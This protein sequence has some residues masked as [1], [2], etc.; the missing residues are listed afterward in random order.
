MNRTQMLA[1]LEGSAANLALL[2]DRWDTLTAAERRQVVA[3]LA[4][5]Q[6]AALRLGVAPFPGI[7]DA[8]GLGVPPLVL[9]AVGIAGAGSWIGWKLRALFRDSS[10]AVAYN[11]CIGA[12]LT[13]GAATTVEDAQR[14]CGRT[15]SPL[16]WAALGGGLVGAAILAV[17]HITRWIERA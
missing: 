9:A 10:A 2:V 16:I 3:M 4:E 15:S 11:E 7:E 5:Y 1:L 12:A 17:P 6:G 8:T 13:T 14:A